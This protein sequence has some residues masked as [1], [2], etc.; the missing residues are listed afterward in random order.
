MFD[1]V[2]LDC[3]FWTIFIRF[4]Q[5]IMLNH[6]SI[7]VMFVRFCSDLVGSARLW[8]MLVVSEKLSSDASVSMSTF[9]YRGQDSTLSVSARVLG[10]E[11]NQEQNVS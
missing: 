8:S 1:F 3:Y 11:I 10:L 6:S 9:R 4:S 5:L 2:I 7:S